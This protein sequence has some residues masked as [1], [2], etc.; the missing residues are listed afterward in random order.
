MK[1]SLSKTLVVSFLGGVSLLGAASSPVAAQESVS[2]SDTAIVIQGY[3]FGPAVPKIVLTLD[4]AVSSVSKE[5]LKVE[6][7]GVE[8]QVQKVYLSD[9]DGDKTDKSSKYITI[10]MPVTFNTEANAA[11]A[12]PF[13][14]SMETYQNNWVSTYPVSIQNLKVTSN[15]ETLELDSDSDAISNR[16]SKQLAAFNNR[17]SY[18]GIYTNPLTQAEE[19]LTLN[20]AA[21]EP[22]KLESGAKNPLIIWLHGQGEG[23]TDTDITLLGN[24][25]TA[26]TSKSIQSHFTAGKQSGAYVLAVQT[27][28][29]WMDEGDGTNGAGAGNSRY[30][31]I[32]MDTIKDYVAN[33]PDVDSNR[34]YLTGGSNGGYMTLNLAIHNPGYFAALVPQAAAYSYYQYERNEDGTYVTVPSDTSLSGT[35]F[36]PTNQ[37]NFDQDQINALKDTPIWFIHAANDTVVD[38][39]KYALPVYKALVDSGASNKWF[40]YYESVEGSDMKNVSYLGHWSWIYF[41]NNQVSGVQDP[42]AVKSASDLTGFSPDNKDQG[43]SSQASVGDTSYQNIFDWMNAQEK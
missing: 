28:T 1:K 41:F 3:E 8:R 16:Q 7:A 39:S 11:E 18:S 26:L 33:H 36:V 34:I 35:D 14:Y 19:E 4:K 2:I 29:Y 5:D 30:T 21:Y 23:G 32:L 20:Y 37:I 13:S 24:E 6:T 22:E 40:S 9:K 27:P 12:T 38:P 25:V 42:N 10:Q 15:K 43:G 31:E 17:S